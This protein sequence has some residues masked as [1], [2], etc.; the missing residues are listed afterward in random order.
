MKLLVDADACPVKE[1]ILSLGKL[2]SVP[3]LFFCDTSH[4]LSSD[5]KNVTV[6]T[7]DR[8]NDSADFALVNQATVGDISVTQDYGLASMLLAKRSIVLHPN[9]FLLDDNNIDQL[10]FQRHIARESRKRK[11]GY[12]P[13]PK[14]T[15]EQDIAFEK[16]LKKVLEAGK[17]SSE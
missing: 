12:S 17:K 6:I 14:R 8:G 16:L 15:K 13:I 1:I 9:G 10:L 3:I 7:V 4:I 5:Q 11:K 2:Y